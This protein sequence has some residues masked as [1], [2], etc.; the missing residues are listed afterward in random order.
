M[1]AATSHP[2]GGVSNDTPGRRSF[3]NEAPSVQ[4]VIDAFNATHRAS[5]D[6]T[7]QMPDPDF[8]VSR[9]PDWELVSHTTQGVSRALLRAPGTPW[10]VLMYANH[11]HRLLLG[12]E[13]CDDKKFTLSTDDAQS[14][15]IRVGTDA[16]LL[17]FA[18]Q[19]FDFGKWDRTMVEW[20]LDTIPGDAAASE[21]VL[22]SLR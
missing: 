16:H 10:W 19:M 12:R 21:R 4:A 22:W 8:L 14:P 5:N 1:N 3:D 9:M 6:Q 13:W 18:V 15:E 2:T 7:N 11:T 20:M 17:R